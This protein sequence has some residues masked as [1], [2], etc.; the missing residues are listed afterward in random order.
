M[1]SNDLVFF[2]CWLKN[3]SKFDR[4]WRFVQ[5]YIP[6]WIVML[7]NTFV[8]WRTTN[9]LRM[10]WERKESGAFTGVNASMERKRENAM[11]R[12]LLFYPA[13]LL[14]SWIFGTINRIQNAIG[15][16]SSMSRSLN[17]SLFSSGRKHLCFPLHLILWLNST[18]FPTIMLCRARKV[19]LL[20]V[21]TSCCSHELAGTSVFSK[22]S[23]SIPFFIVLD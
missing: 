12:R 20:V 11:I 4:I 17:L 8:L 19:L 9:V 10:K 14:I 3:N 23:V 16:W 22:E 18:T 21:F 5:F 1:E 6:L 2:R 7:Y 15:T 13:V